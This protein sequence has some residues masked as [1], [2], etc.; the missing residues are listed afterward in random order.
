MPVNQTERSMNFRGV[1]NSR[2]RADGVMVL[3][4]AL[5]LLMPLPPASA[6]QE[7][8]QARA[9]VAVVLDRFHAAAARGDWSS[10]FDLLT[11]DAVFLGT[12]ASERWSKTQF[13]QYASNSSGWTYEPRSRHVNLA[14]DG[15]SAWFDEIL[16]SV[17]YGT[18]RGS[19][20]LVH[21]EA[22]WK[23]AQYHLSFPIPNPLAREITDRIKAFEN[24]AADP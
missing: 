20:V 12:D 13:R 18:S 10:Y 8:A 22:G 7:T 19:G 17:S 15:Q 24:A 21:T 5:L 14:P 11:A 16:A 1:S 3:V 4:A 9:E 23:I 2:A 6:Q